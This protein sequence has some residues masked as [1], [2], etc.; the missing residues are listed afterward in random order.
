MKEFVDFRF[1]RL[2]MRC[3]PTDFIKNAA[4]FW[5]FEC[6]VTLLRQF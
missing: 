6:T 1:H 2:N 4:Y 5:I 3:S